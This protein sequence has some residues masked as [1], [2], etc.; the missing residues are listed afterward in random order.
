MKLAGYADAIAA[1]D[2][3]TDVHPEGDFGST[4]GIS[5]VY[6]EQY[7][8]F[9]CQ[10]HPNTDDLVV[11]YWDD[12][13][14]TMPRIAWEGHDEGD[15]HPNAATS[16]HSAFAE[17]TWVPVEE[18]A[19]LFNAS[20]DEFTP[21]KFKQVYLDTWIKEHTKEAAEKNPNPEAEL[22]IVGEV[23]NETE[24]TKES[25]TSTPENEMITTDELYAKISSTAVPPGY[26]I[27]GGSVF[28]NFVNAFN[29]RQLFYLR[30]ASLVDEKPNSEPRQLAALSWCSDLTFSD[31]STT[32]L[33][34]Y[35]ARCVRITLAGYVEGQAAGA[36]FEYSENLIGTS[37]ISAVFSRGYT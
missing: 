36:Q 22:E 25:V 6:V 4:R 2:Q 20:V 21:A 1:G 37:G 24:P 10:Y 7:N 30:T 11:R 27:D 19:Q 18:A 35:A 31:F 17:G 14:K 8:V 9:E 15:M 13:S 16:S 23:K 12:G 33:I 26:N 5:V 32:S 34:G 28:T 3:L 29:D